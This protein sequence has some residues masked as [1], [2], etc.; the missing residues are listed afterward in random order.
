TVVFTLTETAGDQT[1]VQPA[2][3]FFKKQADGTWLFFGDQMPAKISLAAETRTNQG[4]NN[5]ANGPDINVDV[6]PLA[7]VYSGISIG[8][9]PC[10]NTALTQQGTE[11]DVYIPDPAPPKTTV[12]VNRDIFFENTGV[13]E[14]LPPAGT[15][16]TVT[17]TPVS[18]TPKQFTV[19]TN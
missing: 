4:S 15:A 13:L 2:Q 16:L 1:Q 3:F 17:L 5:A 12:T 19:Y 10:S 18:G 9:G 14:S 8:G 7:G 6:R 11:Q